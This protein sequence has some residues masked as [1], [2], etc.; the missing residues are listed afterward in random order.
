[1][2][3]PVAWLGATPIASEALLARLEPGLAATRD[4]S[5][6]SSFAW[7][8][9]AFAMGRRLLA[10]YAQQT[11]AQLHVIDICASALVTVAGVKDVLA[12][13]ESGATSV[14]MIE[15]TLHPMTMFSR[16]SAAELLFRIFRWG[17]RRVRRDRRFHDGLA[18]L[19][20]SARD[21]HAELADLAGGDP[22]AARDAE[23]AAQ[24]ADALRVLAGDEAA[25]VPTT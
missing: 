2:S 20:E 3:E 18:A 12:A 25:L 24:H 22:Q 14:A 6:A 21:V 10:A 23:A 9:F 7:N 15:A 8:A 1:M 4:G 5:P 16:S 19:A 13:G 17:T 11:S